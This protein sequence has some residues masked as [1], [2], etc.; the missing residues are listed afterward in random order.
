MRW[1]S[2]VALRRLF[3]VKTLGLAL[4]SW[5]P[6]V[7]EAIGSAIVGCDNYK[8]RIHA[9]A[10]LSAISSLADY[11]ASYVS[12]LEVLLQAFRHVNECDYSDQYKFRDSLIKHLGYT[13]AHMIVLLDRSTFSRCKSFFHDKAEEMYDLLYS[14]KTCADAGESSVAKVKEAEEEEEG[15]LSVDST[16]ISLALRHLGMLYESQTKTIPMELLRKYQLMSV[17]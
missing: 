10:T 13:V 4:A 3:L 7:W 16:N 15:G 17:S 6:K 11:G 1:N 12:L 8:V 5:S 2:C 9:T 14:M